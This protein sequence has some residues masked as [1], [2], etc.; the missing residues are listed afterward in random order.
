MNSS[1]VLYDGDATYEC[2]GAEKCKFCLCEIM[3]PSED[4]VCCFVEYGRCR[5]LA[6]QIAALELL[7]KRIS[8]EL[9]DKKDALD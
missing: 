9:A 7:K 8:A 4:S 5:N 3:P 6:A 2:P 1:V